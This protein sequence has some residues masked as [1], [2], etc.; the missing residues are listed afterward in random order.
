M[1]NFFKCDKCGEFVEMMWERGI[2]ERAPHA[3][4]SL[5]LYDPDFKYK[6]GIELQY[7]ICILCAD[8]IKKELDKSGILDMPFHKE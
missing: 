4:F 6:K 7:S 5:S 2:G 8:K 3:L 1:N